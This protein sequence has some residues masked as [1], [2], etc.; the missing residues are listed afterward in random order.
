MASFLSRKSVFLTHPKGLV[1]AV[2]KT[3]STQNKS[4]QIDIN[5]L[6]EMVERSTISEFRWVDAKDQIADSLT[7][8]GA[9]T[10]KLKWILMNSSGRYDH[11]SATFY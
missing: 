10:D 7:K 6:R 2:H 8:R 1:D 9:S 5:I 3:T 4:L 11:S